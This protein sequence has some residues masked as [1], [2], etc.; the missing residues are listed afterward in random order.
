[1]HDD[2]SQGQIVEGINGTRHYS[3]EF[4]DFRYPHSDLGFLTRKQYQ[5]LC[6]R[7]RGYL[8]RE[9]AIQLRMSRSSV[10]MI[11]SRARKQI[12]KARQTL[13]ILELARAQTQHKVAVEKGTRLQKIP[14]IVLQEA[15]RFGIHLQSNMVDIL[16]MVKK[17][18][19]SCISDGKT[20][21]RI[22]FAFNEKGRLLLQ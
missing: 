16:R 21:S 15:D 17:S 1:M 13:S 4:S 10:S 8:Q 12:K 18:K 7:D 3:R 11:E 2:E 22:L 5:V 9:I 20:T 14:M 19:Q 6:M